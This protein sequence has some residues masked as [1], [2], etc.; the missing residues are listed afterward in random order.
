[1]GFCY[2][3]RTALHYSLH[4]NRLAATVIFYGSP[5]TDPEVLSA[6][7]GPILGIFGGA[8]RSIPVE[9]VEL[10]QAALVEAGIPNEV[11]VYEDQPHAF[12]TDIESIRAGGV[13]GQAWE[14]MLSFLS[15]Y[16]LQR[17][18]EPNSRPALGFHPSFDWG[19]YLVLA[20]EHAFGITSHRSGH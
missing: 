18:D 6:L 3:G 15:K 5:V 20:F 7:P 16:L 8:D 17:G 10:F 12:V 19:Y 13:Q 2:G 1:V 9:D 11:T 14:Q 4:N